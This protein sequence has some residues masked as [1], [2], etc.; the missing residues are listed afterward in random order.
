MNPNLTPQQQLG[1]TETEPRLKIS[2][3]RPG[4]Q[5]ITLGLGVQR[6]S[7]YT[8]AAQTDKLSDV[9]QQTIFSVAKATENIVRFSTSD[10]LSVYK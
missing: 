6:I 1:Y 10:N 8:T 3:E 4:K 9:L 7:N 5:R 2:S